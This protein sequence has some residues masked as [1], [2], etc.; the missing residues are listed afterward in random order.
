MECAPWKW[1]EYFDERDLMGICPGVYRPTMGKPTEDT[2]EGKETCIEDLSVW[3][4]KVF[5]HPKA[6]GIDVQLR[7]DIKPQHK[8]LFKY[9]I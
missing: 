7:F 4:G 6:A 3:Q 2:P 1:E 9:R 5:R 8:V